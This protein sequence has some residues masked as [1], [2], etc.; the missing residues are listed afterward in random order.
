MPSSLNIVQ[1]I[2][3]HTFVVVWWRRGSTALR[4]A[5]V[6]L[7]MIWIYIISFVAIGNGIFAKRDYIIPDPVCSI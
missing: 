4:T 1:A 6:I 2:A 3:L 5:K 7:V